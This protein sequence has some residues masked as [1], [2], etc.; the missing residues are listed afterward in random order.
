MKDS[1]VGRGGGGLYT[2]NSFS[3][4]RRGALFAL[5]NSW[6][7]TSLEIC[8]LFDLALCGR[9]RRCATCSVFIS[10]PKP[11]RHDAIIKV[12][13]C[14][15]THIWLEFHLAFVQSLISDR[16]P[17]NENLTIRLQ[18]KH[19]HCQVHRTQNFDAWNV[20]TII[21]NLSQMPGIFTNHVSKLETFLI[22]KCEHRYLAQG[23]IPVLKRWRS[24]E[25]RRRTWWEQQPY[26]GAVEGHMEQ[27]L[28]SRCSSPSW[29]A[30]HKG[31]AHSQSRRALVHPW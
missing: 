28:A 22:N 31:P 23:W 21:A 14:P 11:H 10:M 2:L 25:R 8:A 27:M 24:E 26:C 9:L 30:T 3:L 29:A 12:L 16:K 17:G 5:Q 4:F 1:L 15:V 20:K 6:E 19:H 7:A 18:R 13:N